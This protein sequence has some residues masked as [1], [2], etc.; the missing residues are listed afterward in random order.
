MEWRKFL[1]LCVPQSVKT[2]ETNPTRPGSP[3]SCKQALSKNSE[4]SDFFLKPEEAFV[5]LKREINVLGFWHTN[6]SPGFIR[7]IHLVI[8]KQLKIKF[9]KRRV[10]FA[11]TK[12]SKCKSM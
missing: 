3:T 8:T 1:F 6:N 11:D 12:T 9:A 2:K 10:P 4:K 7:I 5:Q